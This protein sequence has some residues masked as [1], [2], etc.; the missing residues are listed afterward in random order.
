MC[1]KR[2][3]ITSIEFDGNFIK[4]D[5]PTYRGNRR[6]RMVRLRCIVCESVFTA[7]YANAK[8]IRQ[9]TCS[10]QCGGILT[11]RNTAYR[12]DTHPLYTVWASLRDRCNNPNNGRYPRYGGRGIKVAEYFDLFDDFLKYVSTLKQYPYTNITKNSQTISI[13]RINTD[14]G[15]EVGNLRWVDDSTQAANKTWK[16]PNSSSKYIGVIFCTT[17]KAWISKLQWKGKIHSLYYGHSEE[18]AVTARRNFIKK[19]NLPHQC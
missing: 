10:N 12:A 3:E 9:K 11:R 13:D 4:E 6:D 15:Y 17:N 7:V 5:T 14:K 18:E 2:E 8:R 1:K 16:K 19:Y